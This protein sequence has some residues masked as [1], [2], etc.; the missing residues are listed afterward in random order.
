MHESDITNLI[1]LKNLN[2]ASCCIDGTIKIICLGKNEG[3]NVIQNIDTKIIKNENKNSIFSNNQLYVL[4]QLIPN[5]DIVTAQGDNLIFYS[6]TKNDL[7]DFSQILPVNQEKKENDY[8]FIINNKN[9]CSLLSINY[10][11]NNSLIALNNNTIFFIE[12]NNDKY[13][14]NN[15]IKDICGN[16]GPNN[17]CLFN[18]I[19]IISGGNKIYFVNAKL[20][21]IINEIK[22]DFSFIN[23]INI[24]NNN[25]LFY[26]GYENKN[27]KYN[28]GIYKINQKDNKY[29]LSNIKIYNNVHNKSISNILPINLEEVDENTNGE[30]Y[31]LDFVSGS[32]DKNIKFWE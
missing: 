30:K 6:K 19:I 20:K 16:G 27:N 2:I 29:D 28:I 15:K 25:D 8:D 4:T 21:S 5:E 10:N 1:Q 32:H 23:C 9:I 24:S 18:N 31:K 3:Y 17:I 12:K 7:Y 13:N 14:I 11:E 26:I 22:T